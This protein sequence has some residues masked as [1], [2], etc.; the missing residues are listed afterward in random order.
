MQRSDKGFFLVFLRTTRVIALRFD[1]VMNRIDRTRRYLLTATDHVG[2]FAPVMTV[3]RHN[4][5]HATRFTA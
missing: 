3:Q 2:R 4:S 1:T 5:Y